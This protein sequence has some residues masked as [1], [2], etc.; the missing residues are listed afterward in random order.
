MLATYRMPLDGTTPM[1]NVTNELM[2]EVIKQIQADVAGFRE[3]KSEVRSEFQ[4]VREHFIGVRSEMSAQSTELANVYIRLG[5]LEQRV[6]RVEKRLG[7]V[8]VELN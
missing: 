1:A 5:E 7:L 4:A 8:A 2:F 3:W 6:S